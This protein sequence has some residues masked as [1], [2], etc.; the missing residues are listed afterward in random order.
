MPS[1]PGRGGAIRLSSFLTLTMA[2]FIPVNDELKSILI[3]RVADY[4]AGSFLRLYQNNV[5]VSPSLTLTD[6]VQLTFPGTPVISLAGKFG[7]VL[8]ASDGD[9]YTQVETVWFQNTGAADRIAYGCYLQF[10][11]QLRWIGAFPDPVTLIPNV[12]FPVDIRLD[13][14]TVFV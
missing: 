3:G 11:T 5:N 10:G 2:S 13:Q 8:K 7:P 14:R 9:Y 12:P 4:D 6:L 1:V